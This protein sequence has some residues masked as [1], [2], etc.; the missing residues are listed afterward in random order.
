MIY[1]QSCY[2]AIE[3]ILSIYNEIPDR[4]YIFLSYS[5]FYQLPNYYHI[6]F[7]NKVMTGIYNDISKWNDHNIQRIQQ[8]A[9]QFAIPQNEAGVQV[10]NKVFSHLIHLPGVDNFIQ[11]I[12]N[13]EKEKNIKDLL[14]NAI[15]QNTNN[16]NSNNNNNNI[17]APIPSTIPPPPPP[18]LPSSLFI[19][20]INLSQSPSPSNNLFYPSIKNL[21]HNPFLNIN[22]HNNNNNNNDLDNDNEEEDDDDNDDND[23]N[24]DDEKKT[25]N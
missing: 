8:I 13:E 15:Q 10:W 4:L 21:N 25:S 22:N 19:N 17:N 20:D 11:F 1:E 7:I 18:P 16:N 23:D 6:F 14:L 9:L 24:D 12:E 5:C 2:E 3:Q